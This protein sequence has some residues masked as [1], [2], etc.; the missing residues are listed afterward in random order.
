[1]MA[2]ASALKIML[3]MVLGCAVWMRSSFSAMFQVAVSSSSAAL[4]CFLAESA[5]QTAVLAASISAGAGAVIGGQAGLDSATGSG[6]ASTTV[7]G[8]RARSESRSGSGA[9]VRAR[10]RG[11]DG[12]LR[13]AGIRRAQKTSCVAAICLKRRECRLRRCSYGVLK[14]AL[15]GGCGCTRLRMAALGGGARCG[16]R[17]VV[18]SAADW[19]AAE[20][21]LDGKQ[22]LE[23]DEPVEG[24]VRSGSALAPGGSRVRRMS[25]A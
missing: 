5:E 25:G 10:E 16:A 2:V 12:A 18:G 6:A 11:A 20:D 9:V 21:L 23:V 19:H 15:A 7:L 22:A 14:S 13:C 1:M 24:R 17:R 4:L 3:S 8:Y